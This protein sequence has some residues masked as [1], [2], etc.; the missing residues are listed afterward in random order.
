MKINIGRWINSDALQNLFIFL[1]I[2]VEDF[3]S[4]KKYQLDSSSLPFQF[5]WIFPSL[6]KERKNL[7]LEKRYC[8][9]SKTIC[10]RV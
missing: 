5:L 2:D 1:E 7:L 6:L 3:P 8:G 10:E 9:I 4:K